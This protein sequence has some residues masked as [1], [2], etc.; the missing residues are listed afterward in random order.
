ML[1][2][3]QGGRPIGSSAGLREARIAQ[4]LSLREAARRSG[5]DPGHLSR[6]E[7][8]QS[9]LSVASL[10]RLATV[11]GLRALDRQLAR[12]DP[13]ETSVSGGEVPGA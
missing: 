1:T 9:A 8:G 6:V 7:R 10:R 13:P 3:K 12:I 11:L 2:G 5:I 4:R